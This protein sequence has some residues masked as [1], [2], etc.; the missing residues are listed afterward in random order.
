[1]KTL[2]TAVFAC[3]LALPVFAGP[4]VTYVGQGR[5]ACSG[6]SAE[7]AQVD[8]NNRAVSEMQRRQYQEEQDRAQAYVD[9]SRREERERSEIRNRP[10]YGASR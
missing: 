7:C 6:R 1:M 4:D 2:A 10:P 3:S 5:Y 8:A 9:R